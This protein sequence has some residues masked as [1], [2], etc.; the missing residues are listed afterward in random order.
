[1]EAGG[2]RRGT[3]H[4]K[5]GTATGTR[6]RPAEDEIR[7]RCWG[8]GSRRGTRAAGRA[9]SEVRV[10][11]CQEVH[12]EWKQMDVGEA[13]DTGTVVLHVSILTRFGIRCQKCCNIFTFGIIQG[14]FTVP[15]YKK[16]VTTLKFC[17][18][19]H[20]LYFPNYTRI[21]LRDIGFSRLITTL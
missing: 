17:T 13:R 4:W 5:S 8:L 12:A 11:G 1:M 3:R 20:F 18:S 10:N 7:G 2:G 19:I 14:I 6:A 15:K 9:V 21:F 16:Y